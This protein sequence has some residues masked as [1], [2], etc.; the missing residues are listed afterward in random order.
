MS[1]RDRAVFRLPAVTLILPLLL[2]ITCTPLA[3]FRPWFLPIYLIPLLALVYA[4]VTRTSATPAAITTVGLRGVRR[5]PWDRLDRFE[6]RGSRWAVAVDA[7][8]RR[9]RLPMVRP[10]DLPRLAEVSGGRL[11]LTPRGS[12]TASDEDGDEVGGQVEA[13][14]GIQDGVQDST[15]GTV[16]TVSTVGTV[17]PERTV[18]LDG[19]ATGDVQDGAAGADGGL[20]REGG[21][22]A[23]GPDGP[24]AAAPDGPD[25]TGGAGADARTGPAVADATG[26]HAA[27]APAGRD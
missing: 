18:G 8:G 15:V 1:R 21:V 3:T 13:E 22:A 6:F 19:A 7:D 5:I 11:T 23:D 26:P 14:D 2:F 9:T 10:R 17:G 27:G 16:G 25:G 20:V 4:A 24:D 12:A